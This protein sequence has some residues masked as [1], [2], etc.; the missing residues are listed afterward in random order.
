MSLCEIRIRFCVSVEIA[1]GEANLTELK[2]CD[3]AQEIK[4]LV[5]GVNRQTP[6]ERI[7]LA[8]RVSEG[9]LREKQP[10]RRAEIA[11]IRGK[12]LFVR[13]DGLAR[14][15][16]KLQG[17]AAQQVEIQRGSL[18]AGRDELRHPF[19]RL[20]GQIVFIDPAIE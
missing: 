2:E 9:L 18:G 15:L 6:V 4:V 7:E 3:A 8:L 11:G 16:E 1:M 19:T 20:I 14:L 5:V 17:D 13:I 12:R 10:H